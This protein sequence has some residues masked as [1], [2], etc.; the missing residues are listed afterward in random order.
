MPTFYFVSKFFLSQHAEKKTTGFFFKKKLFFVFSFVIKI[1]VYCPQKYHRR[2]R[3]NGFGLVFFTLSKRGQFEIRIFPAKQ[4][5]KKSV[6]LFPR[7]FTVF[8]YQTG[9]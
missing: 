8:I 7:R 3:G 2:F 9:I 5:V 6:S 4:L 1:T